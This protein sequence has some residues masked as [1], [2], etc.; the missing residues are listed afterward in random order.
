MKTFAASACL[1]LGTLFAFPV[2]AAYSTIEPD[3]DGSKLIYGCAH[4]GGYGHLHSEWTFTP[5]T[6]FLADDM[7]VKAAYSYGFST[8]TIWFEVDDGTTQ[9]LTDQK[10]LTEFTDVTSTFSFT[11]PVEFKS[12]YPYDIIVHC[13]ETGN[14][15]TYLFATTGTASFITNKRRYSD[16]FL[17][18]EWASEPN[19]VEW[20]LGGSDVGDIAVIETLIP[21]STYSGNFDEYLPSISFATGSLVTT[22]GDFEAAMNDIFGTSTWAGFPM[23]FVSPWFGLI[24]ML[25]GSTKNGQTGGGIIIDHGLSNTT[26]EITLESASDTFAA[27]GLRNVTDILFP[28]TEAILCLLFGL[29]VWHDLTTGGK[30][31]ID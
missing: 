15:G 29:M 12:G 1:V 25:Q 27:I 8:S 23:C 9:T 3:I 2:N 11:S 20:S 26:T 30:E 10:L 14:N 16:G 6:T 4:G 5:T 19:T 31:E 17:S 21:T 18:P 28:F 22:G 13:D 24:D 7:T